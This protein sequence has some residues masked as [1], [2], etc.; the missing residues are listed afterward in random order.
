MAVA[1]RNLDEAEQ[2]QAWF[3]RIAGPGELG[4]WN[5]AFENQPG[6]ARRHDTIAFL[7][8]TYVG[9][10]ETGSE[11]RERVLPAVTAALK[12]VR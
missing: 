2:W 8:A 1:Q 5:E 10:N 9:A 11:L 6:L 3:A 4:A 12:V 7:Q